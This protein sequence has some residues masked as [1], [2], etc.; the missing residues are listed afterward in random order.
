MVGFAAWPYGRERD[1]VD[2]GGRGEI[3]IRFLLFEVLAMLP[4]V[5]GIKSMSFAKRRALRSS[6]TRSQSGW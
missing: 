1:K 5:A 4:V 3:S 6:R 2:L